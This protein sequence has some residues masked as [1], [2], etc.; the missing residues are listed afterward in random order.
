MKKLLLFLTLFIPSLVWGENKYWTKEVTVT[1]A[2]TF[3]TTFESKYGSTGQY[4]Q[5]NKL[6]VHGPING[7]DWKYIKG[8]R[9]IVRGR[10]MPLP[11]QRT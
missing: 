4:N 10:R 3:K 5:L 7:A 1:K 9:G 11:N 6:I 8:P 2:G